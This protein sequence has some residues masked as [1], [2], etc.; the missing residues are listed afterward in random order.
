[1]RPEPDRQHS[2]WEP[3]VTNR[4]LLWCDNCADQLGVGRCADCE[5]YNLD[6][7]VAERGGKIEA[8]EVARDA[9][10]SNSDRLLVLRA[11]TTLLNELS[12]EQAKE[13]P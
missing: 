2:Y 10:T 8:L 11:L 1:M 12:D 7:T 4:E 13:R 3:D 5:T 9:L 6:I